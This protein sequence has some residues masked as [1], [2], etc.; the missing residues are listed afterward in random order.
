[1]SCAQPGGGHAESGRACVLRAAVIVY[2]KKKKKKSTPQ[3]TTWWLKHTTRN[4]ELGAK[5][6]VHE[7]YCLVTAPLRVGVA[8]NH[9]TLFHGGGDRSLHGGY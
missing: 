5:S 9:T 8:L 1:M 3:F 4:T 2:W 6:R 7:K